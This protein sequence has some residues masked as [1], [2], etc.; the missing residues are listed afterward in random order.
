MAKA[1]ADRQATS[2]DAIFRA[3]LFLSY[4]HAQAALAFLLLGI[5]TK[6]RSIEKIGR[7]LDGGINQNSRGQVAGTSPQAA[8]TVDGFS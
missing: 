8:S 4:W 6:G 7:M 5:E 2:K 3:F 1:E